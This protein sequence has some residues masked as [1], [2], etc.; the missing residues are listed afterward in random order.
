[1]GVVPLSSD[2]KNA[3]LEKEKAKPTMDQE[4]A[5]RKATLLQASKEHTA[6]II[7]KKV[8]HFVTRARILD[9]D[10]LKSPCLYLSRT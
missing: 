5:T 3:A 1:M 2:I 4:R 10:H 8:S 6:I 7:K 9:D